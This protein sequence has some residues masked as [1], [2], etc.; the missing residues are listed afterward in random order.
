VREFLE[1]AF[2]Q[3]G[4]DWHEYVRTDPRYFRPSEVDHLQ[5]DA[6]KARTKLGWKPKV[7]F[8]ELVKMMVDHDL[9]LAQQ[10]R[11][12]REAGHPEIMRSV[13]HG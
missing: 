3:V 6:T 2:G 7:S 5:G 4:L 11:T 12:L 1:E 9:E 13:A 10:E 8:K